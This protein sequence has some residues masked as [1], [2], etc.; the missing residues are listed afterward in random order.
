[1]I[2]LH[3]PVTRTLGAL[4]LVGLMLTPVTAGEPLA[5]KIAETKSPHWQRIETWELTSKEIREETWHE[6]T[7]LDEKDIVAGF[8]GDTTP[9]VR[10]FL[11]HVQKP[12]EVVVEGKASRDTSVPVLLVHGVILLLD[13]TILVVV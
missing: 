8:G 13:H 5:K 1:M 7:K 11:L 12:E 4:A 6:L 2:R 3:T 10:R 9:P